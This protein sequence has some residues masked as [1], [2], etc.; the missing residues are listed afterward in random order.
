MTSIMHNLFISLVQ[1][2]FGNS[3][4]QIKCPQLASR[5]TTF[6]S[7]TCRLSYVTLLLLHYR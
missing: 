2:Q 6:F 3:K 1:E 4:L 5:V 7:V